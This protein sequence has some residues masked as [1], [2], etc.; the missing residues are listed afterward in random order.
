MPALII[1]K[2]FK[3]AH[4]GIH[5][6]EFLPGAEAQELTD[7]CAAVALAEGWARPKRGRPA[8]QA[9]PAA[10]PQT[11]DAAAATDSADAGTQ[12]DLVG[13]TDAQA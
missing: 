11:A 2:P 8:G 1:I 7:E 3:F 12:A 6:E 10:T 5:V 9:T 13:G 4:G